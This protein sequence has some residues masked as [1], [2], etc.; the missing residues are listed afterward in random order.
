MKKPTI[1]CL[2]ALF[3]ATVMGC[4]ASQNAHVQPTTHPLDQI[5]LSSSMISTLSSMEISTTPTLIETPIPPRIAATISA[6]SSPTVAATETPDV[7]T[8]SE[9]PP[10]T[11]STIETGVFR[12][13][14]FGMTPDAIQAWEG[15]APVIND[16]NGDSLTYRDIEAFEKETGTVRYSFDSYG[17]LNRIQ[18]A[19]RLDDAALSNPEDKIIQAAEQIADSVKQ[20]PTTIVL[21]HTWAIG[22]P[23]RESLLQSALAKTAAIVQ[24]DPE[25]PLFIWTNGQWTPN[26]A[27]VP[28][29]IMESP[30]PSASPEITP[31]LEPLSPL[32]SPSIGIPSST[33]TA[34]PAPTAAPIEAPLAPALHEEMTFSAM[35]QHGVPEREALFKSLQEGAYLTY[36][37]QTSDH[38]ILM[39][40]RNE[41]ASSDA[42]Y[43]IVTWTAPDVPLSRSIAAAIPASASGLLKHDLDQMI[44]SASETYSALQLQQLVDDNGL[45]AEAQLKDHA[46][47]VSG[48]ILSIDRDENGT[49]V[50]L[51]K[52]PFGTEFQPTFQFDEAAIPALLSLKKGE[53]IQVAGIYESH[54]AA[55]GISFTH[56]QLWNH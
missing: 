26:M 17:K 18:Y 27:A 5:Q 7:Q 51:F 56:C 38:N 37:W 50:I 34:A 55:F 39:T 32:T 42:L 1:V 49:P 16:G 53:T 33:P 25:N 14:S 29:V 2:S 52:A 20:S 9:L 46:I 28:P 23:A 48:E 35:L 22:A 21:E 30:A 19:F 45:L 24:D 13:A 11:P 54:D 6:A 8:P 31:Y 10:A 15:V 12:N 43:A 36:A 3:L 44:A 4:S 41:S 47:I 40:I